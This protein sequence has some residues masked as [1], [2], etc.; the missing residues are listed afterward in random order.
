MILAEQC[1][2]G[3]LRD[4]E[5]QGRAFLSSYPYLACRKLLMSQQ[6][7]SHVDCRTT[8]KKIKGYV[9]KMYKIGVLEAAFFFS[10]L[11]MS[12]CASV[13]MQ[14]S[15][16]PEEGIQSPETGVTDGCELPCGF[17]TMESSFQ[18]RRSTRFERRLQKNI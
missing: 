8:K 17:L 9:I 2:S 1:L 13:C 5:S 15:W 10:M 14:Y 11:C 6:K 16:R 3:G 12:L 4:G 7:I 18:H